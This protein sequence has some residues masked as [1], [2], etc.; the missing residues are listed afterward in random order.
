MRGSTRNYF[1]SSLLGGLVVLGLGA[2]LIGTG[3][4]DTG[5]TER[6][7]QQ[8]SVPGPSESLDG[9]SDNSSSS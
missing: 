4:I 2:L 6:I 7:V 8:T 9:S 5:K 3:V 1:L